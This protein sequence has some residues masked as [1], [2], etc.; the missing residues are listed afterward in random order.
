MESYRSYLGEARGEWSVAKNV[1]VALRTGWFSCRSAV[2]L[3]LGKP[4]VV[5]DTGW[6][7]YYPTG[8]GLFSFETLEEAAAALETVDGDYQRH[9]EA[10]RAIAESEFAA[11]KVLHKLLVDCG[12]A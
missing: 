1:Y 4:V 11:E 2:Y 12:V 3:A 5:Q 9:C 7:Q 10:A 6:P 8:R